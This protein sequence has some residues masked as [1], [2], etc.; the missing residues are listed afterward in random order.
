MLLSSLFTAE[1]LMQDVSVGREII[2]TS[3]SHHVC[4][5]FV[6]LWFLQWWSQNYHNWQKF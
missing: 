5:C 3:L 1:T 2:L 6:L 4:L